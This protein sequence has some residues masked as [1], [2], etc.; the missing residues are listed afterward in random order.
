VGRL[1]EIIKTAA[2]KVD[3][4]PVVEIDGI[5]VELRGDLLDA[6][7]EQLA[8][9]LKALD[10]QE[11]AAVETA[12]G[13]VRENQRKSMIENLAKAYAGFR[14]YLERE[15]ET[16]IYSRPAEEDEKE[17][18]FGMDVTLLE[19]MGPEEAKAFV[20]RYHASLAVIGDMAGV[21][22]FLERF[23][24]RSAELI[25]NQE[26]YDRLGKD[27][28]VLIGAEDT[29]RG[30]KDATLFKVKEGSVI[31]V[32]DL[33]RYIANVGKEAAK[34]DPE[35]NRLLKEILEILFQ[36]P[37]IREMLSQEGLPLQKILDD[38]GGV[39]FQPVGHREMNEIEN[40]IRT[41]G[42]VETMA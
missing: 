37:A 19:R 31:P 2:E 1:A 15:I 33:A 32:S 28:K 20:E 16:A 14:N 12:A 23:A 24:K 4:N 18:P 34:R 10:A 39:L 30:V 26:R 7:A 25:A 21:G 38:P 17:N 27:F 41:Q 6:V 42:Y 5:R 9:E 40:L 35:A 36:D 3:I 13:K 29:E 22:K 11:A 8:V